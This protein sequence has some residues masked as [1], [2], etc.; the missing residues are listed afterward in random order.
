MSKRA[1]GWRWEG[2]RGDEES[3]VRALFLPLM[4]ERGADV[5][6]LIPAG[7]TQSQDSIKGSGEEDHWRAAAVTQAVIPVVTLDLPD[8]RFIQSGGGS[9]QHPTFVRSQPLTSVASPPPQPISLGLW[10]LSK[11][12]SLSKKGHCRTSSSGVFC[13]SRCSKGLNF[14]LPLQQNPLRCWDLRKQFLCSWL[15]RRQCCL[16][17]M[18]QKGAARRQVRAGSCV[19]CRCF[20]VLLRGQL[21]GGDA[22]TVAFFKEERK[23]AFQQKPGGGAFCHFNKS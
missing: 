8:W 7:S 3:C 12:S 6:G 19:H 15:L 2:K 9:D 23:R 11:K 20:L 10:G 22:G 17:Q 18:A 5:G 13:C 1:S 4:A 14:V 16:A 21:E